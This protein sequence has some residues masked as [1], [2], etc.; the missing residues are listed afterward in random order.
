[1]HHGSIYAV[2]NEDQKGCRFIVRMPLGN[3]FF[4]PEEMDKDFQDTYEI[5]KE[6]CYNSAKSDENDM[7]LYQA[8][9]KHRILI[10]EDDEEIRKYLCSELSAEWHISSC[11][12]GKEA[13]SM[14]LEKAPDL[15]VS[16]IMMPEMDGMT[17]C[18]KIKQNINI[19][20]I[21]VILLTA[22]TREEDNIEGL[23]IGAD[24]YI[25]KPFNVAILKKTIANL[26]KNRETLKNSFSGMQY[27]E[28]KMSKI[29]VTSPD[30]RLLER[31]M[32]VINKNIGDT[33]FSVES[34]AEEVGI[35]RVH[36]HRK[37]KELTNQT[38]RDFIRNI[39]LQEAASIIKGKNQNITE[40]SR[41][42]GFVNVT[43][44]STA[45]KELYGMT[46]SKYAEKYSDKKE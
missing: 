7:T 26:I 11:F 9:S 24:S 30:E 3:S 21:P 8:K 17:L 13:L 15:V 12:N 6:I 38:T 31:V 5:P 22:K 42:V 36:L 40:V 33:E 1:L 46:P 35:S 27:Q 20:H 4:K 41:A 43:Y 45:F 19:N 37:L 28:E 23:S 2:N 34:L 10:V 14:I 18:R 29:Q 32:K 39:R 16:D 25:T 44:F